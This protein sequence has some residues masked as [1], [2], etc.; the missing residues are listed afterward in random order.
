MNRKRL[1][2]I[3]LVVLAVAL[4]ALYDG[5]IAEFIGNTLHRWQTGET[6]EERA[7]REGQR[8]RLEARYRDMDACP[9][10]A[11]F[12]REVEHE[13]VPLRGIRAEVLVENVRAD[14]NRDLVSAYL[15]AFEELAYAESREFDRQ[16]EEI[17]ERFCQEEHRPATRAPDHTTKAS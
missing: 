8:A 4:N 9:A 11:D 1:L 12:A 15:A 16:L 2:I 3:V 17:V 5:K 10:L 6:A 13:P 7:A 14:A